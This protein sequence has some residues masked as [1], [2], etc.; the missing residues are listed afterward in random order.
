MF[1]PDIFQYKHE[2]NDKE[3]YEPKVTQPVWSVLWQNPQKK[4]AACE[5]RLITRLL[6][7]HALFP[8]STCHSTEL[9]NV[10]VSH[11]RLCSPWN[12]PLSCPITCLNRIQFSWRGLFWH[13]VY[14]KKFDYEKPHT[15]Y[16]ETDRWTAFSISSLQICCFFFFSLRAVTDSDNWHWNWYDTKTSKWNRSC[17]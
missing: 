17:Q 10:T 16:T 2:Y 3:L 7:D 13:F 6:L 5:C 12:K 9:P 4:A 14:T 1:I 15:H 11:G 8:T